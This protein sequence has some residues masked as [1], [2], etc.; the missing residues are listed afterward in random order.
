MK[1]KMLATLILILVI[2]FGAISFGQETI[3]VEVNYGQESTQDNLVSLKVISN[4]NLSKYYIQFSTDNQNWYGYDFS[5][6]SWLKDYVSKYSEFYPNFNVGTSKGAKTVYVR[7]LKDGKVLW[8]KSSVNLTPYGQEP[9]I[10][11]QINKSLVENYSNSNT[12]GRGTIENPY[13]VAPGSEVMRLN[14]SESD[15]FSISY[16]GN[17]W[18]KYEK[19]N[20]GMINKRLRLLS[21]GVVIPVYVKS[22][23]EFGVES[24]VRIIY[25]VVDIMAPTCSVSTPYNSYLAIG[26]NCELILNCSDDFSDYVSYSI[27]MT[28]EGY[29]KYLSGKTNIYEKGISTT[30]KI[31]LENLPNGIIETKVIFT[32]KVGNETIRNFQ[33]VSY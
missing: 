22:V 7:A 15:Y 5:K 28:Y 20:N 14:A 1:N 13:V 12:Y 10:E 8:N 26:G 6:N 23:N 33:I 2:V 24:S 31:T 27:T 11:N 9:V 3:S 32:D 18:S 19:I 17:T 4:T 25:Y 30:Q 21:N 16:D 29:S